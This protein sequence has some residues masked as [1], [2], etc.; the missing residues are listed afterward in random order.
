MKLRLGL[1]F[2]FS[3]LL[4]SVQAQEVN[5]N[6]SQINLN[7]FET[8]LVR[9]SST[10]KKV[11][12]TAPEWKT[13]SI[14]EAYSNRTIAYSCNGPCFRQVVCTGFGTNRRCYTS[15]SCTRRICHRNEQFCSSYRNQPVLEKK[16]IKLVFR[17]PKS[18]AGDQVEKYVLKTASKETINSSPSLEALNA[19][20]HNIKNRGHGRKFIVKKTNECR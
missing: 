19:N 12:L 1:F 9:T 15:Y 13:T 16:K 2:L 3:T 5:L 20:C 14:C 7:S 8:T 18:L 11:F 17:K 10:P 4:S 6:A